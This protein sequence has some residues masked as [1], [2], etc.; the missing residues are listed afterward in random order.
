MYEQQTNQPISMAKYQG[1]QTGQMHRQMR[2]HIRVRYR[3]R[4]HL[5]VS[6][7]GKNNGCRIQNLQPEEAV[8]TAR[9]TVYFAKLWICSLQNGTVFTKNNTLGSAFRSLHGISESESRFVWFFPVTLWA[10]THP[11]A[12]PHPLLDE[13]Q[14]RSQTWPPFRISWLSSR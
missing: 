6:E 7:Y 11:T 14:R 5:W 2:L 4:T 9:F 10:S 3:D 8:L 12:E 1:I 13:D